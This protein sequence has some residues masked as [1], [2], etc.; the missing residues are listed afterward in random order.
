[1]DIR[2]IKTKTNDGSTVHVKVKLLKS[3]NENYENA[4]IIDTIRL[5]SKDK[6][7]GYYDIN[8]HLPTF[9]ILRETERYTVFAS[10]TMSFKTSTFNKINDLIKEMQ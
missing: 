4:V 2:T 5:V 9:F 6:A 7:N 10:R 3:T 8:K 1:M